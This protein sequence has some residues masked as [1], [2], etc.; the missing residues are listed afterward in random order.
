MPP[1]LTYL[2]KK[3][4]SSRYGDGFFTFSFG[5]TVTSASTD[6]CWCLYADV[7]TYSIDVKRGSQTW[8]VLRRFSEF[9]ALLNDVKAM[10]RCSAQL[11]SAEL[12]V[13][14]PKTWCSVAKDTEYLKTR[15]TTLYDFLETLTI[16]LSRNQAIEGSPLQNFLGLN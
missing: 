9:E 10:T 2:D 13:L 11:R 12:P 15:A 14:P 8:T 4:F 7:V 6:A 5:P 16:A 3:T 1:N